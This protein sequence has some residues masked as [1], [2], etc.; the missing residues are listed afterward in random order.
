VASTSASSGFTNPLVA[1]A[2]AG[3]SFLTSFLV[4]VLPWLAVLIVSVIIIAGFF[5]GKKIWKRWRPAP[6]L[7]QG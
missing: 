2:E 5:L 1:T 4:V 6:K 3:F 7:S